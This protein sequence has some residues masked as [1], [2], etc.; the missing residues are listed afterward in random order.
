MSD[1]AKARRSPARRPAVEQA[2][3]DELIDQQHHVCALDAED[4]P[5]SSLVDAG[6]RRDDD[7]DAEQD[8]THTGTLERLREVGGKGVRR[9]P[10]VVAGEVLQHAGRRFG[11]GRAGAHH[12][13]CTMSRAPLT[14][15]KPISAVAASNDPLAMMAETAGSPIPAANSP[16]ATAGASADPPR[17]TPMAKP[18]AVARNPAGNDWATSAYSPTMPAL[19]KK[20]A[21]AANSPS[22]AEAGMIAAEGDYCESGGEHRGDRQAADRNPRGEQPQQNR[23]GESTGAGRNEHSCRR[24][25][26]IAHVDDDLGIHFRM[27]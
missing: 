1:S 22:S 2:G 21:A 12:R 3:I 8:L 10:Q 15:R 6:I 17:P 18:V 7:E 27:K 19:V 4:A 23:S 24:R 25:R 13:P 5:G 16:P 26:R 20:P 11:V 14:R 9:P